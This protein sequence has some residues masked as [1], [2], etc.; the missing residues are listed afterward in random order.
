MAGVGPFAIPAAKQGVKYVKANDLNP[1]SYEALL[2]NV[3]RN[4]VLLNYFFLSALCVR[5]FL[6]CFIRISFLSS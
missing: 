4:K 2:E 6:R 1:H 3:K 5:S